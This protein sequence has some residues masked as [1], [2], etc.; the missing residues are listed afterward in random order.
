MQFVG[1]LGVVKSTC[2]RE[3]TVLTAHTAH[4]PYLTASPDSSRTVTG[5]FK[6]LGK[7]GTLIR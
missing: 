6:V 2:V 4:V 1:F 5:D 3:T 7:A